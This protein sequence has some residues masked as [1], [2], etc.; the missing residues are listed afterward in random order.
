MEISSNPISG[1]SSNLVKS[2]PTRYYYGLFLK[3]LSQFLDATG[4]KI[5]STVVEIGPGA[6]L[7]AGL[8]ALLTGAR[9]YY[10]FDLLKHS[11]VPT[12]VAALMEL[13]SMFK[14]RAPVTNATGFPNYEILLN[15]NK[16]PERFFS[17]E[18][19]GTTLT[20]ERIEEISR[21]I[22]GEPSSVV[23]EYIAPWEDSAI[24]RKISG[25]ADFIFSHSTMEHVEDIE[26]AYRIM[27][28]V[29]SVGGGMSHQIDFR[30]HGYSRPWNAYRTYDEKKWA[31]VTG[32]SAYSINRE[33]PSRHIELIEA[34]GF[35]IV[36]LMPRG[37]PNNI[38]REALAPRFRGLSEGDLSCDGLFV[39]AVRT[40]RAP[41]DDSGARGD[42]RRA[43]TGLLRR[44]QRIWRRRRTSAT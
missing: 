33:P 5:P 17:D 20:S 14:A 26:R 27:G 28:E 30:S 38:R 15:E 1:M 2:Q 42:W 39:Q 12:N 16:F 41:G 4:Q 29:C 19:L 37:A 18:L 44:P 32:G 7:S 43:L 34:S 23:V 36:R 35:R 3:H 9:D 11:D 22:R 10:A 24:Y 21:A 13:A 6:A 25:K 40:A 31:K 8:C